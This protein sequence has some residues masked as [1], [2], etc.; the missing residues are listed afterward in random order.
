MGNPR[1]G[2][3]LPT[4]M[5]PLP[6]KNVILAFIANFESHLKVSILNGFVMGGGAGLS[7]HGRFRVVTEN[8][9]SISQ[10][11]R[12][13]RVFVVYSSPNIT[14]VCVDFVL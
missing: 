13:L 14:S 12:L 10:S 6:S 7:I 11:F 3:E 8:T 2:Y 5:T 9:V 4:P 1:F